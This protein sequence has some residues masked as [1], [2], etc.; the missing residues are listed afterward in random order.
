VSVH[1]D[2]A[3]TVHSQVTDHGP[4]DSS[5]EFTTQLASPD[6]HCVTSI[7]LRSAERFVSIVHNSSRP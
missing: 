7:G 1:A 4:V 6:A 3:Y 2:A 5:G